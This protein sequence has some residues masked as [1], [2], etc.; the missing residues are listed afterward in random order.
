MDS[1]LLRHY[2]APFR[3]ESCA[4]LSFEQFAS[5]AFAITFGNTSILSVTVCLW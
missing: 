2:Q 4:A 3:D 5:F 1:A